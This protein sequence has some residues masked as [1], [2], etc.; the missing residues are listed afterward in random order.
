MASQQAT[1]GKPFEASVTVKNIGTSIWLPTSSPKGPVHL[2]THLLGAN[3]L[4][5][6]RDYSRHKLTPGE[7]RAIEPGETV[8][9]EAQ[10]PAPPKGKYILEFDLVSEYVC[11]FENNGS[12]VVKIEVEVV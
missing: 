6:N 11:W 9:L 3:G 2:G 10:V 4:L 8:T 1:E 12:N 5:I 7:G